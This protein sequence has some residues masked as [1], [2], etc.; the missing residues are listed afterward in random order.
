MVVATSRDH[1]PEM[2][3]L[4]AVRRVSR[5]VQLEGL[6]VEA[7][8]RMAVAQN[9]MPVDAV[10]LRARTGGNPLVFSSPSSTSS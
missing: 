6:D 9:T 5:L 8:H 7:V 2:P 10:E 1:E 3:R 4:D